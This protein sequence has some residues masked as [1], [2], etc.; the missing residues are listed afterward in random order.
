[1]LKREPTGS[2]NCESL[3]GAGGTLAGLKEWLHCGK[4]PVATRMG[5]SPVQEG[6]GFLWAVLLVAGWGRGRSEPPALQ[7]SEKQPSQLDFPASP[8]S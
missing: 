6:A 4:Q 7:Q 3:H 8:S 2:H 5:R 1:M